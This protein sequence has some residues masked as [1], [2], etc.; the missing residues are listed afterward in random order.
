[1]GTAGPRKHRLTRVCG[2]HMSSAVTLGRNRYPWRSA[3]PP[4]NF[5]PV[6][7]L[8]GT[9]NLRVMAVAFVPSSPQAG[10]AERF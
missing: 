3:V 7:E 10:G 5:A 1:M 6:E 9:R 8:Q 2:F 4:V